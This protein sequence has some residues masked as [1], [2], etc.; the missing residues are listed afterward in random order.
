MDSNV[1]AE[2]NGR[3][4]KWTDVD[5]EF[6]ELIRFACDLKEMT[7][8]AFDLTVKS[9][10]DSWGYDSEYSFSEKDA[11]ACGEIELREGQVKISDEID[12]GGIGKGYALD[13]MVKCLER[14][15]DFFINAG[16]DIYAK[17]KDVDVPWRVLFED[18]TDI[19]QAIGFVD[20]S[21]MALASSNPNKR[22]WSDKHHLVDPRS[23]RPADEMMAVYTQ[24]ETCLL[25]DA[26][27]TALFVLGYE[28]AKK[29]VED[30]P[31]EAMLVSPRGEIYRTSGFKGELFLE[32]DNKKA[33]HA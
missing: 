5:E 7:G 27:S 6:F 26:Y 9:V 32:S 24:A 16:G 8:G 14:L 19:T 23:L 12:L 1:L 15:D 17:G 33:L 18:P 20:V 4:G 21:D 13:R 31:V 29:M 22:K 3:V 28:G 10:L 25:A 11:G 30:F 2:L